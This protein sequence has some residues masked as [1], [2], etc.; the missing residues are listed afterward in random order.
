MANH[1][2]LACFGLIIPA[3]PG[4]LILAALHFP[5]KLSR[6]TADDSETKGDNSR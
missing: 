3:V 6:V 5:P 2:T 1:S 4:F